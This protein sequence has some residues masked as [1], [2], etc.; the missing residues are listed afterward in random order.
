MNLTTAAVLIGCAAEAWLLALVAIRGQRRWL[1]ATYTACALA[2]LVGG[3]SSVGTT[4]GLLSEA[5]DEVTLGLL[6]V[7][8]ALTAILVLGLI[9]G[10]TLPRQRAVAFLL[11]APVPVLAWLAPSQ[12]WTAATA[13]EGNILGGFLV[14]CLGYA[15]AETIY[16]RSASP[17]FAPHAF[18]LSV[19]VVAL[20]V[21]GPVYTY[22]LQILGAESLAGANLAAPVAL[23][24]F[25]RVA[26]QTDPFPVSLRTR[27]GR[28]TTGQIRE[29]DAIVFDEVRPKYARR[30]A[31]EEATANRPTLILGR[32]APSMTTSGV[33]FAA[34]TADRNAALRVLTTASEF[35]SA[36]PGSLAVLEDVADVS[37]ISGWRPT[38]EAIVRL[39]HVARDTGSTVILCP[40]R[41]TDSERRDLGALHLPTWS[42]PDPSR[43]I[44]AI[45]EHSFGGGAVRL[46]DSFG[47]AHGLRTQDITTEHVPALLAFLARS[48][49]DLTGVVSEPAAHGLRIQFEAAASVLRSY[50]MQG[51]SEIS[52]GK[53]PSRTAKESESEL[54]VTA[55]EY[56]KGKEMEE[57]FAAAD[58]VVD[59][60]PLFERARVV[61]VEQLGDAG[62]GVLRAQLARLGKRPEDLE[63]RDLSRIADRATVDLGNLAEVVDVPAEKARIQRQIES[64]R[65]QLELIAGGSK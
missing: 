59:E 12:N 43:E 10:E 32:K 48:L 55:T 21:G 13:F 11:L 7:A 3:A 5:R 14:L 6:L 20:I 47:R 16:A 52:R 40:S 22:E 57:L 33:A 2:L 46:F 29:A 38:R 49:E 50:A 34:I 28:V 17:M 64:I 35:L 44:V 9:H 4:E 30:V 51:P 1:Q 54:L 25:A 24:C 58:S 31:L 63:K 26:L 15:L 56:W 65:Q 45:L 41:L 62:E 37:S 18:W 53:W 8:H 60:D 27:R 19:G 36:T 42:L 23:A 61:F 39:R